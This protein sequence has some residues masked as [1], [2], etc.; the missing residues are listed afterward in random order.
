[1]PYINKQQYLNTN[2]LSQQEEQKKI[3]NE[4]INTNMNNALRSF[5]SQEP[6]QVNTGLFT[7]QEPKGSFI[8]YFD[9]VLKQNTLSNEELK[10][11]QR[12]EKQKE[13]NELNNIKENNLKDLHY[14]KEKRN[15]KND[16]KNTVKEKDLY[17]VFNLNDNI[18]PD[19]SLHSLYSLY[20]PEQADKLK[21]FYEE[22]AEKA[23]Q[24][25]HDNDERVNKTK[26]EELAGPTL[27]VWNK[28]SKQKEALKTQSINERDIESNIDETTRI[29]PTITD[30]MNTVNKKDI[31]I[32]TPSLTPKTLFNMYEKQKPTSGSSNT[33]INQDEI[34]NEP[35]IDSDYEENDNNINL[36]SL[37]NI[38]KNI[39]TKLNKEEAETFFDSS[40][41]NNDVKSEP[42]D[43]PFEKVEGKDP[44]INLDNREL[45]SG[46]TNIMIPQEPLNGATNIMTD[47]EPEITGISVLTGN[48]LE[49]D[50][51]IKDEVKDIPIKN[52]KEE[53]K[54]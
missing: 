28:K 48:N 20:F 2:T 30:L 43:I 16:I 34:F 9:N 29:S 10:N 12:E 23:A 32:F 17:E 24:E 49:A 22:R 25:I 8:K 6:E 36:I 51:P 5:S 54:N 42:I 35:Q 40:I 44:L 4:M 52:E 3:I 47:Q 1:M 45:T 26:K 41:Y 38:K 13:I 21:T 31:T 50:I 37:K 11:K 19:N 46:T 27:P 53:A 7:T 33:M 15:I 18:I 14:L 39:S